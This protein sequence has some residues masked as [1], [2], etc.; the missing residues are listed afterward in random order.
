MIGPA[1]KE[2]VEQVMPLLHE[3]IG[4][5]AC[6][7]AG[8]EDEAE[9]MRILADFYREEGNRVSY[10]NVIVDKRDDAVAGIV[11]CYAGDKA[12]ELDQPLIERV[13]RVTG[14]ADYS[15]L[16]ETRPGEFYLDSIAVHASF[17]NQGI[18]KALM[19]AFEREAVKQGYN[20]VSLIVEEYNGQARMLYEKMG[21][22]EDGELI[23]SGHRYT[24]MVKTV[25]GE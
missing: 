4:N 25:S 11:V 18:A 15:I 13:K 21:Y 2:D 1:G 3:A 9:A 22:K 24:R 7:L 17:R 12:E 20:L 6:S 14:I 23:V 8:V 5:I 16:T 19:A 10:R